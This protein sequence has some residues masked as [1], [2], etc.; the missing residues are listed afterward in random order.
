MSCQVRRAPGSRG[1]ALWWPGHYK[2]VT[3][4][5]P[6]WAI[7]HKCLVGSLRWSSGC[8]LRTQWYIPFQGFAVDSDE[9]WIDL[10]F[11]W[12][13]SCVNLL[14][15]YGLLLQVWWEELRVKISEWGF[16]YQSDIYG[17]DVARIFIFLTTLHN[18][19]MSPSPST[20]L[21]KAI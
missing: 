6:L 13:R 11:I 14:T 3:T 5:I 15:V 1:R 16:L 2:I 12:K 10:R 19:I 8:I 20:E 21:L 7:L 4:N 9:K 17:D 18:L